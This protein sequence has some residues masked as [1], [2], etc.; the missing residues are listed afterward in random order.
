MIHLDVLIALFSGTFLIQFMMWNYRFA[1][2]R[3][4]WLAAWDFTPESLGT[5]GHWQLA[6][7]SLLTL[8]LEMTLIRWVSSEVRIFAYFKNFVLIACFLGFGATF[9]AAGSMS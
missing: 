8:F 7:A 5:A 6:V 4:R 3:P 1:G 2:K 9:L